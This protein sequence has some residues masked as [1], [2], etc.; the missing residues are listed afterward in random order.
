[1]KDKEAMSN[2][3]IEILKSVL[4][5]IQGE[6]SPID[7]HSDPGALLDC[8]NEAWERIEEVK[9]ALDVALKDALNLESSPR[10]IEIFKKAGAE[11]PKIEENLFNDPQD[12]LDKGRDYLMQVQ[13][14]DLTI[15][16]CL[17]AFGW[18]E[19]NIH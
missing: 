10:S 4:Q 17:A 6:T 12:R 15:E 1:M 9:K 19:N 14:K 8:W 5:A 11:S 3:S 13:P 2:N 18:N 7:G 16:D